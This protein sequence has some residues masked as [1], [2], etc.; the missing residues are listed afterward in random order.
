M[1]SILFTCAIHLHDSER[2]SNCVLGASILYIF[3]DFSAALKVLYF[4]YLFYLRS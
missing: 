3:Y 4:Y 1:V 2:L